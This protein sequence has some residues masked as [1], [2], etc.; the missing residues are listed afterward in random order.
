MPHKKTHV[1]CR[2]KV[3]PS[4]APDAHHAAIDTVGKNSAALGLPHHDNHNLLQKRR[5]NLQMRNMLASKIRPENIQHSFYLIYDLLK[6]SAT[7]WK[8]YSAK[9][10]R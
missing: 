4:L 7:F 6:L 1:A 10:R 5:K 2:L 3:W 9:K 8:F